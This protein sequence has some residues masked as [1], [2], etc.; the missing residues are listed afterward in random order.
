MT[1]ANL[2]TCKGFAGGAGAFFGDCYIIWTIGALL[3][4]TVLILRKQCDD[5]GIPFNWIFA[6]VGMALGL[7]ITSALTAS[8]RW[9]FLAALGGLA[10]GG[11]VVGLITGAGGGDG[12][13]GT[14]SLGGQ[15]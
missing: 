2:M 3:V 13:L 6:I 1:F 12:T 7:L 15:I 14:D 4:L 8:V 11:F 9:S 5:H 10:V